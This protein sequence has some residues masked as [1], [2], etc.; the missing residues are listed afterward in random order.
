M[1]RQM[2]PSQLDEAQI[3]AKISVPLQFNPDHFRVDYLSQN[4]LLKFMTHKA[5]IQGCKLAKLHY[6]FFR[7]TIKYLA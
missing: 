6:G 7:E 1:S 5:A 2:L 4:T 3:E